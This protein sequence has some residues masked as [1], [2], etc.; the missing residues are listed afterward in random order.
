MTY[1]EIYKA[2]VNRFLD[3]WPHTEIELEGLKKDV[4]SLKEF[5]RLQIFNDDSSNFSHAETPNQLLIGHAIVEVYIRRGDGVGRLVELTDLCR[6]IFNNV[7]IGDIK[8]DATQ[9]IDRQQLITGET[10]VDPNWVSKSVITRFRSP[11]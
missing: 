1:L 10:V 5:V 6:A 3:N 9:I 7:K 11:I 2:I 8:F 4:D